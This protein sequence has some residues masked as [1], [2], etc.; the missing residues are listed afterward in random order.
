MNENLNIIIENDIIENE[1]ETKI[2]NEK[3][4]LPSAEL[5]DK[6]KKNKFK[7]FISFIFFKTIIKSF[8]LI[9]N[10]LFNKILLFFLIAATCWLVIFLLFGKSALPG[11]LYFS[12]AIL[13]ILSH[14]LGFLF[15]K[16]KLPSLLGL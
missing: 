4:N 2:I 7:K 3:I 12:L 6:Q 8:W 1:K 9:N 5:E 13:L 11:G 16:L 14:V 10:K 15:E